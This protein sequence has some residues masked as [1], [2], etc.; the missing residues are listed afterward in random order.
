KSHQD[1]GHKDVQVSIHCNESHL[2]NVMPLAAFN[3]WNH[4]S[5]N[6]AAWLKRRCCRRY[7]PVHDSQR[8]AATLLPIYKELRI[9]SEVALTVASDVTS[10]ESRVA[11]QF[12]STVRE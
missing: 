7:L 6:P 3:K 2:P 8:I 10:T 1:G 11:G 4:M 12:R 5:R 9:G